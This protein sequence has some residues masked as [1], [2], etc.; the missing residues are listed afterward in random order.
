MFHE[1]II[2]LT[3]HPHVNVIV[4]W[5]EALMT[6][7]PQQCARNHIIGQAMLTAYLVKLHKQPQALE[8]KLPDI[9]RLKT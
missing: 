9:I 8:L 1:D 3:G 5:N 2:I 7:G 4:P 6:Y